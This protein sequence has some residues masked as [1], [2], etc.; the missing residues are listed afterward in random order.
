MVVNHLTR[1]Y[2]NRKSAQVLFGLNEKSLLMLTSDCCRR[3][4]SCYCLQVSIWQ[5]MNSPHSAV[6]RERERDGERNN[7]LPAAS[8]A[9]CAIKVKETARLS[10]GCRFQ[11]DSST[12]T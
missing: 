4:K 11:I 12:I 2:L 8:V 10:S 7:C 3:R 5:P 1:V 9:D 6:E